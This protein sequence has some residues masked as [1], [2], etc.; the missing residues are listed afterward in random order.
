MA[1]RTLRQ[2]NSFHHHSAFTLAVDETPSNSI[3]AISECTHY[4]S[5]GNIYIGTILPADT[6]H[7][8]YADNLDPVAWYLTYMDAATRGSWTEQGAPA[9]GQWGW[10]DGA[11]QTFTT[12][13][14]YMW[15]AR[16]GC[17]RWNDVPACRDIEVL[18][19]FRFPDAG[20]YYVLALQIRGYANL[21]AVVVAATDRIRLCDGITYSTGGTNLTDPVDLGFAFAANTDYWVK[22]RAWGA[23]LKAKI[24]Q[25]GSSEPGAWTIEATT[26]DLGTG[27]FGWGNLGVTSDTTNLDFL[28]VA[29]GRGVEVKS[30]V[31]PGSSYHVHSGEDFNLIYAWLTAQG[32]YHDL[33]DWDNNWNDPFD[34]L[35]TAYWTETD[36]NNIMSVAGGELKIN[37]TGFTDK[38]AYLTSTEALLSGDFD[39]QLDFNITTLDWP[40]SSVQYG[41]GLELHNT[42]TRLS[43]TYFQICRARS[44][45]TNGYNYAATSDAWTLHADADGNGILRYVRTGSTIKAYYWN[46]ALSRWEWN[47]DTDGK[48]F[49][50]TT[51][52]DL[53]VSIYAKQESNENLVTEMDNFRINAPLFEIELEQL[54]VLAGLNAYHDHIADNVNLNAL[55]WSSSD[56]FTVSIDSSKV[57]AALTDF[58]IAIFLGSP[59]HRTLTLSDCF[60]HHS[61]PTLAVDEAPGNSILAIDECAHYH[62]GS[63]PTWVYEGDEVVRALGDDYKKLSVQTTDGDHCYVEV[64]DWDYANLR[65]ILHV[66]VPSISQSAD[67]TLKLYYDRSMADNDAW[68]GTVGSAPAKEVWDDNFLCVYHFAQVMASSGDR[69]L[70]STKNEVHCNN[71]F[72]DADDTVDSRVGKATDFDGYP[73]RYD[74][75]SAYHPSSISIEAII[76]VYGTPGDHF[77]ILSAQNGSR[78]WQ[79]RTEPTSGNFTWIPWRGGARTIASGVSVLDAYTYVVGRHN[80]TSGRASAWVND[81]EENFGTYVG[82]LDDVGNYGWGIARRNWDNLNDHFVG[83]MAEIRMSDIERSDAWCKATYYSLLGDLVSL[84]PGSVPLTVHDGIHLHTAEDTYAWPNNFRVAFVDV[85]SPLV[86]GTQ[87]YTVPGFGTPKAVIGIMTQAWYDD[88]EQSGACLSVGLADGTTQL[89]FSGNT[90]DGLATQDSYRRGESAGFLGVWS[91]DLADFND[92]NFSTWITDGV[93]LSWTITGETPHKLTLVLLSGDDL[94]AHVAVAQVPHVVDT[95]NNETGLG[96]QPDIVL[97]C[98]MGQ[99]NNSTVSHNALGMGVAVNDGNFTQMC[100]ARCDDDG[101]SQGESTARLLTDRCSARVEANSLDLSAEITAFGADGFTVTAREGS[102]ANED[103]MYLALAIKNHRIWAGEITTPTSPGSEAITGPGFQPSFVMQILSMLTASDTTVQGAA[104]GSFGL[105]FVHPVEH[106]YSFNNEYGV[107]TANTSQLAT[108]KAVELNA[109]DASLAGLWILMWQMAQPGSGSALPLPLRD[110]PFLACLVATTISR[111][112]GSWANHD[113]HR[114]GHRSHNDRWWSLSRHSG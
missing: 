110:T 16:T 37:A 41:A 102:V 56:Y 104:A 100:I 14:M 89:M 95:S 19:K 87:D 113:Y 57:D 52:D 27:T 59:V 74:H 24:W 54:H 11:W 20:E 33:H 34:S 45:G 94:S 93:R 92:A 71:F 79:F 1:N 109:D 68:V 49:T 85:Y 81:Q 101:T 105:S 73:E 107:E 12:N 5:V 90:R 84:G 58:P 17:M 32:A 111:S 55:D 18:C 31:D 10:G 28:S 46:A 43:G 7:V 78:S 97:T 2:L 9:F 112:C 51:S 114:R 29:T 38:H 69:L 44:S 76:G 42:P 8:H 99:W 6:Y 67:T 22:L 3:L 61:V 108:P 83:E 91:L 86:G 35:R 106:C 13:S 103:F 47:G 60:H 48:T 75:R 21:G 96:F 30:A 82:S 15:N 50:T 63:E 36:A 65:A 40:A 80:E 4:H 98:G 77:Q 39:I 66:K 62:Y 53:Y 23:E 64:D 25:D 26:P 70:D 88:T 72:V